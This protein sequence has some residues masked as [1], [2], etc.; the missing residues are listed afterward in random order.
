MRKWSVD[1]Y[2]S[3]LI[4]PF[5]SLIYRRQVFVEI[6]GTVPAFIGSILCLSF[7]VFDL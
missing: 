5:L 7:S 4:V 3:A 6:T 2:P 1:G